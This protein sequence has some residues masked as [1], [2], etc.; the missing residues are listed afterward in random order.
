MKRLTPN[1]S[2]SE[3]DDLFR[4][5]A[6][7]SAPPDRREEIWGK[8]QEKLD[9]P[10][11]RRKP[12][13]WRRKGPVI[14]FL[15][16]FLGMGAVTWQ[17]LK[18]EPRQSGSLPAVE[19]SRGQ[20]IR[21]DGQK[22]E[23]AQGHP[24][25]HVGGGNLS[26]RPSAA[27]GADAV[28]TLK[29]ER[30]PAAAADA[31]PLTPAPV[32]AGSAAEEPG[33]L[34]FSSLPSLEGSSLVLGASPQSGAAPE[35]PV[36]EPPSFQR[37][38]AAKTSPV[39][40]SRKPGPGD[41][42][43]QA[44][45]PKMPHWY[46]GLAAGPDWSS[47]SARGWGTGVGGGLTLTYRFHQRWGIRTGVLVTKKIYDARPQDY[48]PKDDSWR[49]YHVQSIDAN[50]SVIEV[51]LNLQYAVW[52]HGNNRLW[53]NTGLSSYW[54]H[55]EQYTY[56]YKNSSGLPATWSDEMY[57]QDHHLFSLLNFSA[58]YERSWRHISLGIEPYVQMPLGGIG[59]GR[60]KLYSGG[61]RFTLQ[62]SLK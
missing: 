55:E 40:E 29:A 11:D 52:N 28:G 15:L 46:F 41:S 22:T 4:E 33:T 27:S 21:R 20:N 49:S 12:V 56:H 13:A 39:A 3:L 60:V 16:L 2:D 51:P 37:A 34:T 58:A 62:Y 48:N 26:G 32:K 36:G 35:R 38:P 42:A 47:A 45:P 7:Q 6:A 9:E 14:V 23:A 57:G 5:S 43:K 24:G 59:Y 25:D 18:K 1:M 30:P 19:A 10:S 54:M 44:A 31:A 8:L 61:I 17:L 53:L 50:C